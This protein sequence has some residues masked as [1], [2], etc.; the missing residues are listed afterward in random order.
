M[1]SVWHDTSVRQ[2]YKSEHWVPCCN[3]TLLRYDLKI[4]ESVAKPELTDTYLQFQEY[5][6]IV[7][8]NS[9]YCDETTQPPKRHADIVDQYYYGWSTSTEVLDTVLF[10]I[11]HCC[12][13][14]V[15][16]RSDAHLP[17]FES[18]PL[19]WQASIFILELSWFLLIPLKILYHKTKTN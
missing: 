4:V 8:H 2:P 18:G 12:Y 19:W 5:S 13:V 10:I 14:G 17:I 9:I 16:A 15:I 6:S 3:Q 7:S 1:S 11:W